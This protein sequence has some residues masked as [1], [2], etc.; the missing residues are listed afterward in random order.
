MAKNTGYGYRTG[1]IINRTQSYNPKTKKFM[2]RDTKTGQFVSSKNTPFKNV[3]KENSA[4][5]AKK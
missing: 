1:I 5:K 3:K 2:K 4:K